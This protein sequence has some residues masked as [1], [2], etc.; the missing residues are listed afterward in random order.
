MVL[1]VVANLNFFSFI[2]KHLLNSLANQSQ[3]N[4]KALRS[5]HTFVGY[6]L[7]CH[8]HLKVSVAWLCPAL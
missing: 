6:L 3:N 8:D 7:S 2:F 4:N 1:E 5:I